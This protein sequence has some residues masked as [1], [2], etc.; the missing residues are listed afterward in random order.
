MGIHTE[1][2]LKVLAALKENEERLKEQNK[3]VKRLI[4]RWN[5]AFKKIFKL[6]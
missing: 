5:K 1:E 6:Y 2:T 4:G 3:E